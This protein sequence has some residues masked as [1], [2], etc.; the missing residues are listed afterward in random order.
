MCDE[1][2][3]A[4][5]GTKHLPKKIVIQEEAKTV[6]YVS[7]GVQFLYNIVEHCYTLGSLLWAAGDNWLARG[8][9]KQDSS[10]FALIK[11]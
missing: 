6:L 9:H 5:S 4:V 11:T 3:V 1:I 7:D 10:A 2:N 8:C